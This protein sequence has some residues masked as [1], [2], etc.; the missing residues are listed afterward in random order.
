MV[1]WLEGWCAVKRGLVGWS[2]LG[3]AA[4]TLDVGTVRM[5][6]ERMCAGVGDVY[7]VLDRQMRCA[8]RT[9]SATVQAIDELQP[10]AR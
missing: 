6:G 7:S 9:S 8:G 3:V 5:T 4:Y 2:E 1:P 10:V